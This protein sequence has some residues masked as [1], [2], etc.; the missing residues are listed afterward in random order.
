MT[1]LFEPVRPASRQMTLDAD[2]L[3]ARIAEEFSV[4]AAEEMVHADRLAYRGVGR[5]A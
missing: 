4:H 5:P 2:A 3:E 1:A